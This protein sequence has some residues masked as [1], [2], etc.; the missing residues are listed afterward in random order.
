MQQICE[1]MPANVRSIWLMPNSDD[2]AF[3]S[4]LIR[5]LAKRFGTPAFALH[6]TLRGGTVAPDRLAEEIAVA[7]SVVPVGETAPLPSG[8]EGLRAQLLADAATESAR[9]GKP[10]VIGSVGR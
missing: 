3:H 10:V 6:L 7:A 5:D 2:E 1:P 8:L 4:L 9:A